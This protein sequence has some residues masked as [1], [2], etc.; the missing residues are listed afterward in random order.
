MAVLKYE[1]LNPKQRRHLLLAVGLFTA[2]WFLA[3]ELLSLILADTFLLLLRCRSY[4]SLAGLYFIV[5]IFYLVMGGSILTYYSA[6]SFTR[7]WIKVFGPSGSKPEPRIYTR[8]S[9]VIPAYNEEENIG[10]VLRALLNQNYPRDLIEI[11]VVDD[12]STDSTSEIVEYYKNVDPRI[13]LIR[14]RTNLGKVAALVD[15]VAASNGDIII[16]LDADTIPDKNAV[17]RMVGALASLNDI[18]AV[19]GMV[20]PVRGSG[21]LY[22]LQRIE[23][24][25]AFQIGRFFDELIGGTNMILSGSFSGFRS[26]ILKPIMLYSMRNRLEETLAEDFDLTIRVWK[27]GARTAYEEDAIAYTAIPTSLRSLYRQKIR[28]F[29][30]GLQVLLQHLRMFGYRKAHPVKRTVNRLILH[31]LVAEYLLPLLQVAGFAALVILLALASMGVNVLPIPLCVFAAVFLATYTV[32]IAMGSATIVLSFTAVNGAR[33]GIRALPY[34]V[35]YALFYLPLLSIAKTDSIIRV[36]RR[37]II[38]WS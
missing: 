25:L 17:R 33:A 4:K 2:A 12:G 15:G 8:V 30:G 32:S 22:R 37:M 13:R 9:I 27:R 18:G 34:A 36:A 23:Y 6:K 21:L 16:L 3:G 19:S 26:S 11:V 28:W 5:T 1:E 14:H 7:L 35:I 31:L 20:V 24:L 10:R 38:S 29:S